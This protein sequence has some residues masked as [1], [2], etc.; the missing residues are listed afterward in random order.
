[1]TDP[2]SALVSTEPVAVPVGPLPAKPP[3]I[4]PAV[5]LLVAF[6]A[7]YAVMRGA[8]LALELGFLGWL[9]QL[10]ATALTTL[11]FLAWWCLW[12]RVRWVERLV[13]FGTFVGTTV[14]AALL[15]S[16][17]V[18][19]LM[20][21]PGLGLVLAA[22]TLVLIGLRNAHVWRR[23]VLIGVL[24]LAWCPFLLLRGDGL[25]GGF[26]VSV[27]W[28]WTPTEEDRYLAEGSKLAEPVTATVA[29][30]ALTLG[31]GDWPGF[32][33]PNRDAT[34][35][36]VRIATDWNTAP[37]KLLWTRRI[38]PAWSSMAVIGDRLFTQEQRAEWE[39]VV[40]LDTAT[41]QTLWMHKDSTRHHDEQALTGPRAAPTFAGGRLYALGATGLLNCLDAATGKRHWQRDL[42]MDAGAKVPIWGFSSSPLVVGDLVIVHAPAEKGNDGDKTLWAFRA[43]TGQPVWSAAAGKMSYSSPQ[44]AMVDGKTQLLFSSDSGLSA[45]DPASGVLLWH[46]ETPP[47]PPGVPR[48]VQPRGVSPRG[49]LVD[50]GPD[51]GTA[52]LEVAPA[53]P[54]QK[55]MSRQLKPNFNDFVVHGD[56]VYGID[57]LLLTCIDLQTG[58]RRWKAGRY[59]AGQLLLLPDQPLLVVV[60]DEGEAVLVA[61]NPQEHV[62]LGRFQAVDGKTWNHP[63]VAHGRLYVRNAKEIACYQLRVAGNAKEIAYYQL[64]VAG[65][66]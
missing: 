63:V 50:C 57:G 43:D 64:R 19:P 24:C 14:A 54:Q 16:P 52:L 60:T 27:L 61:V 3:R 23:R 10:G 13:V 46:H 22:W 48:A 5:G 66:G 36:D 32:R 37:P 31:P 25:S 21:L 40:C 42:K 58:K 47:G 35:P 7:F 56:A 17:S 29:P 30:P 15:S 1:M 18:I 44:L 45:F 38:G 2:S 51:L 59:G 28:R 20:L 12:S 55:W 11:L 8:G 49:V 9:L 4:W 34:V 53:G 62:E 26:E 41:G 39:T 33:G 65:S 6:W